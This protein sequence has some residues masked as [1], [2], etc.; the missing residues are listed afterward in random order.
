MYNHFFLIITKT[1]RVAFFT[2]LN[3]RGGGSGDNLKNINYLPDR[4]ACTNHSLII[5]FSDN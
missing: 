4:K 3:K 5:N 2:I 1:S